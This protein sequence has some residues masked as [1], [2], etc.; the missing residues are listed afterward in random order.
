[1]LTSHTA[2]QYLVPYSCDCKSIKAQTNNISLTWTR[3]G[4]E[5][6]KLSW[7]FGC[8]CTVRR[9]IKS[10]RSASGR[11][12]GHSSLVHLARSI[13]RMLLVLSVP[14][15]LEKTNQTGFFGHW[16][17][18]NLGANPLWQCARSR[19]LI[20]VYQPQNLGHEYTFPDGKGL[21]SWFRIKVPSLTA[22]AMDI[23]IARV[24]PFNLSSSS[25]RACSSAVDFSLWSQS[26]RDVPNHLE[27]HPEAPRGHDAT[28]TWNQVKEVHFQA[29]PEGPKS[30]LDNQLQA[31]EI[32][33]CQ[34]TFVAPVWFWWSI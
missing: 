27:Y 6:R 32:C 14:F 25:I 16:C 28:T 11:S 17:Q 26:P 10:G 21:V 24:W 8:W 30:F 15:S 4:I 31:C 29:T 19:Q 7:L 1:M 12:G 34:H 13:S 9:Y 3:A 18:A 22:L 33:C 2:V 20:R 23:S 5:L